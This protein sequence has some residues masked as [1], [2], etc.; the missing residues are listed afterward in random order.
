MLGAAVPTLVCG[1]IAFALFNSER[2]A[3]VLAL[4]LANAGV[5]VL[6]E[7]TVSARLSAVLE[8]A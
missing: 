3:L 1:F 2:S 4:L 7:L 6:L 5:S 8:Q